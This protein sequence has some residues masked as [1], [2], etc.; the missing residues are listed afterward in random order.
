MSNFRH[1]LCL[2][3]SLSVSPA[4]LAAPITLSGTNFSVTYDDA[5]LG[6]YGTPSLLG[7]DTIVFTPTNF[8]ASS[9][10]ALVT[11]ASNLSLSLV[12]NA[13][14][15]LTGLLFQ[16]NGD[17]FRIGGGL[18]N[19]GATLTATNLSNGSA[20]SLVLAPSA[21]LSAVTSLSNF[22]TTNWDMSGSHAM[23]GLGVP[24]SMNVELNN[25]LSASAMG[26]FGFIEKKFVGLRV[27]AQQGVPPAAVPEPGSLALVMAGLLAAWSLKLRGGRLSTASYKR[28]LSQ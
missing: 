15:T 2:L 1:A 18:V 24:V 8:K 6:L 26:G 11:Q 20:A 19:V 25:S 28:R 23:L 17:Y 22:Q 13:G 9:S 5:L 7:G 14:Y 3:A 12:A 10:G 27:S 21:P 16:E 4:L